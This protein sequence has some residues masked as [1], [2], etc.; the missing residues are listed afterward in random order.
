MIDAG[1][2]PFLVFTAII[3]RTE[4]T[5][6]S[7][8]WET[9]FATGTATHDVVHATFLLSITNGGIAVAS[10]FIGLYL[11]ILFR[12]I[13]KLPPDMN[14][15]EDNLTARP[16]KRNK[17]E[18]TISDK[19]MSQTTLASS[20][21]NRLS[22]AADP[23]IAPVRNVPFMHTRTDSAENL[24]AYRFS[25]PNSQRGSRVDLSNPNQS[26]RQ[27]DTQ[28]IMSYRSR[29]DVPNLLGAP[30]QRSTREGRAPNQNTNR[31]LVPPPLTSSPPSRPSSARTSYIGTPDR[32]LVPAPLVST[33]PSRPTTAV[34]SSPNT[35][36]VR[37][38]ITSQPT[39]SSIT[40]QPTRSSLLKENWVSYPSPSPSPS[41]TDENKPP[42][43]PPSSRGGTPGSP[44]S[45]YV[46]IQD[47]YAPSLKDWY[48]PQS[49]PRKS[50]YEP[51]EQ[52][53]TRRT[54]LYDFERDVTSPPPR[55]DSK[56]MHPLGMNPP[57]PQLN[58]TPVRE[59][60]R[61]ALTD[62]DVNIPDRANN[63]SR[64]SLNSRPASFVGSGGK[65]RFYGDLQ[66]GLSAIGQSTTIG[67]A[68]GKTGYSDTASNYSLSEYETVRADDD[69]EDYVDK[70]LDQRGR[71]ISN[72]NVDV[73]TYAGLGAGFGQGMGRRRDV[74]GKV[75]EEGR[76]I[77]PES[78]QRAA[79]AQGLTAGAAGWAR[80][81]GL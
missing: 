4:Y 11:A 27:M 7:Y 43:S 22:G 18:L 36:G 64:P 42:I 41:P 50:E 53:E 39:R 65:T 77:S 67:K 66:R 37:P 40:S 15:L 45:A 12:K 10:L 58:A 76:A 32:S 25:Q 21:G 48:T 34:N 17:S 9:L 24:A 51:L 19:H 6:G 55:P 63:T 16:H 31:S 20:N 81:K 80:W 49:S 68:K 57:T 46:S 75:A 33:P 26:Q 72:T 73:G 56:P 2:I 38:G 30:Q 61:I 14:P 71:V 62:G 69:D 35:C 54:S 1:L 28:S 23:L 78:K 3:S 60:R 79:Q 29:A 59:P 8:G 5:T 52:R 74:S 70:D 13:A 47:S 44:V